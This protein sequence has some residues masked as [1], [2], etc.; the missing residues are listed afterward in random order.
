MCINTELSIVIVPLCYGKSSLRISSRYVSPLFLYNSSNLYLS[1]QNCFHKRCFFLIIPFYF[2]C[3]PLHG[4]AYYTSSFSQCLSFISQSLL[5]RFQY[6]LFYCLPYSCYSSRAIFSLILPFK[7][8]PEH[9]LHNRVKYSIA[10]I[11]VVICLL[12]D[13]YTNV[14]SVSTFLFK[15]ISLVMSY[16]DFFKV[17]L[18]GV[19]MFILL[20]HI[21]ILI[22][23][24]I[25]V[26][27][28]TVLY[29]E[30]SDLC[31][32]LTLTML[33]VIVDF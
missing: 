29:F 9:T 28:L 22:L 11:S 26:T 14:K 3:T 31:I 5:N 23:K 7:V 17:C 21:C 12:E 27:F 2:L 6:N 18:N 16:A 25:Y 10:H 33:L 15:T 13:C 24:Q 30:V 20:M 19:D 4:L 1:P 32:A 8:I